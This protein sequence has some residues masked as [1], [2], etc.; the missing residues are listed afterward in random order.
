MASTFYLESKKKYNGRYLYLSCTQEKN[1]AGNKSVIRWTLVSEGGSSNYYD[2]GPTTVTINGNQVYHKERVSWDTKVFPASKGS[3]S[4][5]LEVEHDALGNKTINVSLSTAIYY[6]SWDVA[7]NT[8]TASWTLDNI[9]RQA[10]ITGAVFNVDSNP[11]ISFSP[12]GTGIVSVWLEPNPISNH[13][14][15]RTGIPNTGSYTWAL[16]ESEWSQLY[17]SFTS[18]NSVCRVG[19]NTNI[20]GVDY[21][22]YL[23]L[24]VAS[25]KVSCALDVVRASL[26]SNDNTMCN[27]SVTA[28]GRYKD[29]VY[30]GK[31][32]S[33]AVYCRY[34][35]QGGSDWTD[36]GAMTITSIANGKYTAS[37]SVSGLAYDKAYEIQAYAAD[38]FETNYSTTRITKA[39]P[40]FDWSENDFNFNVPMHINGT[41]SVALTDLSVYKQLDTLEADAKVL[42]LLNRPVILDMTLTF[43]E[44]V[45]KYTALFSGSGILGNLI[46]QKTVRDLS[47]TYEIQLS[48]T[49]V[50][51]LSVIPA[52]THRFCCLLLQ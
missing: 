3:V 33:L 42:R 19:I 17:A 39:L 35:Q 44:Q 20:D 29:G 31:S 8:A 36:V 26:D 21:S 2:I 47:A 14:C 1:I 10:R 11:S 46:A 43:H 7:N 51:T 45:P 28:L 32:N 16:T 9:T 50:Q 12:A 27:I 41:Q 13:L 40:V 23:D 5:T 34:R 18:T 6:G 38:A 24:V 15:V 30:F 4:G 49:M 22:E 25:S 37:K 52:G 48:D